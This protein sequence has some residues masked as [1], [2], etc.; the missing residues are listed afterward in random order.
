[1]SETFNVGF[2]TYT[3]NNSV[4]LG[5][6]P[7]TLATENII[8]NAVVAATDFSKVLVQ[9]DYNAVGD[10]VTDD[11][12]A[13]NNAIAGAIAAGK[14]L[15]FEGGTYLISATLSVSAGLEIQ[16]DRGVSI[17]IANQNFDAFTVAAGPFKMTGM[18]ISATVKTS[19]FGINFSASALATLAGCTFDTFN[20]ITVTGSLN[21]GTSITD[22]AFTGN[23]T[24]CILATISILGTRVINCA[25]DTNTINFMNALSLNDV[26]LNGNIGG[27]ISKAAGAT[28]F[29]QVRISNCQFRNI[30]LTADAATNAD[31]FIHNNSL[32]NVTIACDS[33]TVSNVSISDNQLVSVSTNG[34]Q[35]TSALAGVLNNSTISNNAIIG[36][37]VTNTGILISSNITS[38]GV[39]ITGN[40]IRL[41]ATGIDFQGTVTD[42]DVFGNVSNGGTTNYSLAAALIGTGVLTYDASDPRGYT[43]TNQGFSFIDVKRDYGAVGD[44]VT[45]DTTAINNAL[46]GGI[47]TGKPVHFP[48]GT[49]RT[50]A[51]LTVPASPDG[52]RLFGSSVDGAIIQADYIGDT[53]SFTGGD[54]ITIEDLTFNPQSNTE[55]GVAITIN[56]VT[57]GVTPSDNIN[58]RN[59]H[60][61]PN[62]ALGAIQLTYCTNVTIRDCIFDDGDIHVSG[63]VAASSSDITISNV[64]VE[65]IVL[66]SLVDNVTIEDCA[67]LNSAGFG[68]ECANDGSTL[69]NLKIRGC[70]IDGC[71]NDCI[72]LGAVDGVHISACTIS[73]SS[74]R[75]INFLTGGS[76]DN[77]AIIGN[78]I[79]DND[80]GGIFV[81]NT[82]KVIII[83]NELTANSSPVNTQTA[84]TLDAT[85]ITGQINIEG[86]TIS[87]NH[88]YGLD[89]DAAVTRYTIVGND[90]RGATAVVAPGFP[91]TSAVRVAA[92]NIAEV[93]AL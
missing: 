25:N 6:D 76:Q 87:G 82:G 40:V 48:D 52:I 90:V 88:Q 72:S 58:I 14:I 66:D 86:N 37:G 53:L 17:T 23:S 45:D 3:I 1:M 26:E 80:D 67:I 33:Q 38:T 59:V 18:T 74:D 78:C 4:P 77:V 43:F 24:D 79:T 39:R 41:Y 61:G 34:I 81:R 64:R 29:N 19:N 28:G 10:G 84:I 46:A 56:P 36:P 47:S 71:T 63:S 11:T 75:G 92:S 15:Y 51:L 13:I 62:A 57:A 9:R 65:N 89:I 93:S 44:G 68:I 70:L 54:G 85:R 42:C 91:G 5:N 7:N 12:A 32:E 2:T 21:S 8:T 22:C 55:G 83:G 35:F 60:T 69:N 27:D 31:L 30:S 50:T 20:G 49:Y 16:T 73:N